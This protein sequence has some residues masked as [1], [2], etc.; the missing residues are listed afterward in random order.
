MTTPLRPLVILYD[1]DCRF[2]RAGAHLARWAARP[3]GVA[4]LPF[5]DS[6]AIAVL[7][8]L[9]DS[10]RHASLHALDGRRLVSATDAFRLALTRMR[11][12]GILIGLGAHRIYPWM[13]RNRHWIGRLLPDLPR[14]PVR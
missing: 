5:D 6:R 4:V 10:A 3:P 13:V 1:G 9:P 8:A 7:A 14:P 11:F 2:C 12:G